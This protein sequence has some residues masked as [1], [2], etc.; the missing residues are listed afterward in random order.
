MI[1]DGSDTNGY[2]NK[3]VYVDGRGSGLDGFVMESLLVQTGG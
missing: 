1:G 3:C 2:I